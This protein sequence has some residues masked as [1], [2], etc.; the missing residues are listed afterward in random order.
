MATQAAPP[1]TGYQK[2][3]DGIDSAKGNP[4]WDKWDCEI[5]MAVNEY[6]R[7]LANTPGY[8]P[9]D[10]HYVKAI[11]WTE[12]GPHKSDWNTRPI[13]IGVSTD[14]G[15]RSF[16]LD[17]NDEH[18]EGGHLIMLP[19]WRDKLTPGI[20]RESPVHNLR[21]GI[22]YLLMKMAHYEY[23]I[24]PD[25]D[26]SIYEVTVKSGDT[27]SGIAKA[28]GSRVEVLKA[29]NPATNPDRLRVGQVLKYQKA[30]LQRVIIGWRPIS[31]RLLW[32]RYNGKGD[33]NY[34]KKIDYALS[35][36]RS[37]RTVICKP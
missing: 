36:V 26:K 22:G 29:L 1:R 23:Q 33:G 11:L 25:T 17:A 5:R 7:H 31:P 6:N 3:Q 18:N 19:A 9:L 28:K 16:L 35:Q 10:W 20:I 15:M 14:P 4:A 24:V 30:S 34:T 27:F 32:E 12:T 8:V 21:A 13:Q 2:W 37:R